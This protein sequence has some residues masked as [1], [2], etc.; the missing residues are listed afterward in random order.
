MNRTTPGGPIRPEHAVD[1][2]QLRGDPGQHW[3]T[4]THGVYTLE[5]RP[6]AASSCALRVHRGE[7]LLREASASDLDYLKTIAQQWIQEP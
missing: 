5:I 4:R 3:L 1:E 7:I 6:T 2:W